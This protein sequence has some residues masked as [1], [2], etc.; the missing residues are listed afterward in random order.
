MRYG[1]WNVIYRFWS[2]IHVYGWDNIPSTGPVVLMGNHINALDPV[3]MISFYPDRDIVPLAK[4]E[5]FDQPFLRYF[6]RHWGAIRV[7]RGEADLTALKSVFHH[8]E[9]NNI[10]MLYAEGTRSKTGLIEGQEGG[11]YIATKTDAMIVPVAIWGT[12]GFPF[13]WFKDFKLMDIHISF[14]RPFR[15]RVTDPR[16]VRQHFREMT[17]E[18]MFQLST[19]LPPKWRG[20]YQDMSRL[21]TNHLDFDIEWTPPTRRIPSGAI[22]SSLPID[23]SG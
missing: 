21:S 16:T 9:E 18:I 3:V 15:L 23:G 14:G 19:L 6:V 20:V 4:I 10:I 12:E 5:A 17:D 11:A 1:I 13:A 7:N 22:M 2:R 8:L